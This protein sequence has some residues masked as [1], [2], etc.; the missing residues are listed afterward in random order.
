MAT[1]KRLPSGKW[2]VNQYIDTVNGKRIYKSFTHEDKKEAQYMAAEYVKNYMRKKNPANLTVGE[3]IDKY[4][5][6]KDA[7]LSP[8]TI[9][10]YKRYRKLYLQEII[11]TKL[12][13]LTPDLVQ[14]AV[15]LDARTKSQK[16]V[17]NAHGLLS[18]TLKEFYPDLRLYTKL[19]QRTRQEMHIPTED[20]IKHL[21][22]EV[23]GNYMESA[24]LLGA[25][26]G[27]RRSEMCALEIADVDAEK[28][29]MSI[30][31]ALVLADGMKWV[32]KST[33]SYAG[34]R[35]ITADKGIIDRII[36]LAPKEGPVIPYRPNTVTKGF[37]RL[38][39][40]HGYTFR[41]HDL[42]HYNASIMLALGIPDKY[43]MERMGHATT[44]MLKN[45]Y[46]H[47]MESKKQEVDELINNHMAGIMQHEMQH[48]DEENGDK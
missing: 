2:R 27:L 34:T 47:T 15:N 3:A 30:N 43:A 37:I 31:K 17:R 42:R 1:A 20:Q 35:T 36:E 14:N 18:S 7:V 19:P 45:V 9:R 12:G 26:L 16:T 23:S 40:K 38:R 24:I 32:V 29:T 21:L 28:G 11:N 48:E 25:C 13:I 10:I 33:K 8:S 6:S 46:Q 41:L 22:S 4:I 5:A 39:K 44:N